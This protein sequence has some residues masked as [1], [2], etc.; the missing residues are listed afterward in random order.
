MDEAHAKAREKSGTSR[1]RIIGPVGLTKPE[2]IMPEFASAAG[3]CTAAFTVS[4][5][6]L[7]A[8]HFVVVEGPS[9]GHAFVRITGPDMV[10]RNVP[11]AS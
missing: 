9:P 1:A 6:G 11:L 5:A 3:A 4:A 2:V 7:V 10:G 8:P